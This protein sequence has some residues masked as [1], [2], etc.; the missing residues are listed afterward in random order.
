[1]ENQH[2]KIGGYRELNKEEIDMM[3][4][5]KMLEQTVLNFISEQSVYLATHR[6]NA[7]LSDDEAELKRFDAAEPGRWLA[8]G[9]TDIQT[10]FMAIV[11]SIAQPGPPK[12]ADPR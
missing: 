6:E 3:N 2:R 4:R 12:L 9:K 7:K 11:R 5:A 10:G 8:I 1:M